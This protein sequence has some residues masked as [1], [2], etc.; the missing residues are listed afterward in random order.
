[1][2]FAGRSNQMYGSERFNV[3]TFRQAKAFNVPGPTPIDPIDEG[4]LE[5]LP[6]GPIS[7]S[8]PL[9]P[10]RSISASNRDTAA[11]QRVHTAHEQKLKERPPIDVVLMN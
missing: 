11:L 1:M 2:G 7:R 5:P 4:A 10:P 8:P 9:P 3:N 6:K